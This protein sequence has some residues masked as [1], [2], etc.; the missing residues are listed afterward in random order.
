MELGEIEQALRCL[1][2]VL[3]AV[4]VVRDDRAGT[5]LEAVYSGDGGDPAALSAVLHERLPAYMVPRTLLHLP[6]LPLNLNGKTDR[7]AVTAA[8][9][10]ARRP[11]PGSPAP[12]PAPRT[13]GPPRHPK[14]P[15]PAAHPSG[16]E[17]RDRDRTDDHPH[18]AARP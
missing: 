17:P 6:E 8:L 15:P 5:V 2:G 13:T 10:T 14:P 9:D 12:A 4:V 7:A 18:P 3:D 16:K 1:P 11:A